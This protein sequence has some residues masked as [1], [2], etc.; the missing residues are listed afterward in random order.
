MRVTIVNYVMTVM[1]G[2]G[3]TRDLAWARGLRK[4][5]VDARFLSILPLNGRVRYPVADVPLQTVRAPYLRERVYAMQGLPKTG[6][7]S[8]LLLDIETRVFCSRAIRA[9]VSSAEPPDLVHA[10][11][12]YPMVKLKDARPAMRVVVRNMGGIA[13]QYRHLIPRADAIIGDG[14]GAL[15]FQQL[16]GY[17]IR[18]VPGGI[19]AELFQPGPPSLKPGLGL[20][21]REVVLFAGRLAPLKNLPLLLDALALLLRR[22]P[23][24]ALIVAGEGIGERAARAQ[25]ARLGISN[26]V[27]FVGAVPHDELP[28]YYNAADV[29]AL[30]STFD[31]SPN[32]VL[33]AMACGRPVVATRVGGVPLYV[34]DGVTGLLVPGGDPLALADA[35]ERVLGDPRLA[36]EMAA[37][38]RAH[39]LSTLTWDRST[40]ALLEVYRSVLGRT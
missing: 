10:S 13:P 9:I 23:R 17:P 5:G 3:E 18:F 37:R 33:E 30:S 14:S 22:R 29:F 39:V 21:G 11:H 36:A 2:G 25:V 28:D 32:A 40:E 24:A 34:E 16:T 7:L 8:S 26:A 12:L 15:N 19:D 1:R 6:R 35:L 31:N 38:A 27:R 20:E 4:R